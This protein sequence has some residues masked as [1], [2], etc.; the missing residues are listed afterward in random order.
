LSDSDWIFQE[1]ASGIRALVEKFIEA[2]F[3][4]YS[5]QDMH[6]YLYHKLI[7]GR[8][9]RAVIY[10]YSPLM[11]KVRLPRQRMQQYSQLRAMTIETIWHSRKPSIP[12]PTPQ[13]VGL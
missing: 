5:E 1:L 8:L 6:A 3:F 10:R 13:E 7:S 2:P 11:M 4:F 9:A 12:D